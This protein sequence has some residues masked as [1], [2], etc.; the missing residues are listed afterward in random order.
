MLCISLL[1]ISACG[2]TLFS[3]YQFRKIASENLKL[4]PGHCLKSY[5]KWEVLIA[6]SRDGGSIV[7]RPVFEC[8]DFSWCLPC[9]VGTLNMTAL[10]F[11]VKNARG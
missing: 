3:K 8:K 1:G 4:L 7:R 9:R 11:M 6:L 2:Y 5:N 10:F